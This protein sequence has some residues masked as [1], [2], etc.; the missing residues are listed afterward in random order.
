[1]SIDLVF[2]YFESISICVLQVMLEVVLRELADVLARVLAEECERIGR[3]CWII[4]RRSDCLFS[5][6][7]RISVQVAGCMEGKE[8]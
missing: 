1:M 5:S 2:G 4:I 8:A 3:H 6:V 7:L